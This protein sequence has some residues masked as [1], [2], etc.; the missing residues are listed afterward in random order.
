MATE[1]V[2]VN[3]PPYPT[4]ST[5]F[6]FIKGLKEKGIPSRIDKSIMSKMSGSGQS[7]L[8]A[9]LKWLNLIDAAGFPRPGLEALANTDE[10]LYGSA[11]K[12]VLESSYVFLTDGSITLA[13]ATTAQLEQKFRDYGITGSTV[14]RCMAF[15]IMAAKDAG[16]V[17]GPHVKTPKP[18]TNGAKRKI[19]KAASPANGETDGDVE[20]LEP[21]L[22]GIPEDMPGF[23]KIPIPLHGMEDGAVFLPD[24][25]TNSQWAYALKITKF[26]IENYRPDDAPDGAEVSS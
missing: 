10:S 15:F 14:I 24:N 3:T 9:T 2:K 12:T 7:A 20:Y 21:D 18:A 16:I 8:M 26:L 4:Y 23:V 19:K 13:K 22:D 17:L 11:L 25:M 6:N 1:V 5:F